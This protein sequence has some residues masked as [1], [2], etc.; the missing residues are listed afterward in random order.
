MRSELFVA[1][2]A[3]ASLC[4]CPNPIEA[5]GPSGGRHGPA[6]QNSGHSVA[7][8]DFHL[9]GL[10]GGSVHSGAKQSKADG[11]KPTGGINN[12]STL[13]GLHPS[14]SGGLNGNGGSSSSNAPNGT[15]SNSGLNGSNLAAGC[16]MP[17]TGKIALGRK[18]EEL[19]RQHRRAQALQLLQEAKQSGNTELAAQ[20]QQI[21]QHL[22]NQNPQAQGRVN[23][24]ATTG[25]TSTNAT[26]HTHR[27]QPGPRINVSHASAHG[28]AT[29][30]APR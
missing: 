24:S 1:A 16:A 8:Q 22:Q 13:A 4:F 12:Q 23:S 18:I 15:A 11:G 3:V 25:Q 21:F 17:A 7:G 27:N 10:N 6:S 29:G 9:G 20:A 28:H 26:P 5:K 14:Q 30:H 2:C 19:L